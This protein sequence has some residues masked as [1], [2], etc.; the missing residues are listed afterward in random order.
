MGGNGNFYILMV[1]VQI[2]SIILEGSLLISSKSFAILLPGIDPV[3]CL[4]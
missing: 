3:E 1:I 4:L 2:A